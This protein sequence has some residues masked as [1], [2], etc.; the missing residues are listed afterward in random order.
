MNNVLKMMKS[1]QGRVH[2]KLEDFPEWVAAC[3]KL[4]ALADEFNAAEAK[5]RSA[6]GSLAELA[7]K[8]AVNQA[9]EARLSEKAPLHHMSLVLEREQ[10]E[11]STSVAREALGQQSE[12]VREVESR[13]TFEIL[14]EVR[15]EHKRLLGNTLAAVVQ[16]AECLEAERVLRESLS[17]EHVPVSDMPNV[18]YGIRMAI[19][20]RESWSSGVNQS[21]RNLSEYLGKTWDHSPVVGG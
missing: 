4:R 19:G 5:L 2:R 20:T 7:R 16:L 8:E 1:A 18:T 11:F 13:C 15:P 9:A 6:T 3:D 14:K 10:A 17:R 21:G 12:I